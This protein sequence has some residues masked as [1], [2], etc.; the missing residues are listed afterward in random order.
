MENNSTYNNERNKLKLVLNSFSDAILFETKERVIEFVNESFCNLFKIKFS[1]EAVTGTNSEEGVIASSFQFKN[2]S[3]FIYRIE[4]ILEE[5]IPVKSEEVV[6]RDGRILLRDYSSIKFENVLLGHLWIYKE[7]RQVS[8]IPSKIEYSINESLFERIV[9]NIPVDIFVLNAQKQYIFVNKHCLPDE[10]R[11]R[12]IIGKTDTEYRRYFSVRNGWEM[13]GNEALD[14]TI[15]EAVLSHFEI[16]SYDLMGMECYKRTTLYPVVT[17]HG[18]VENVLAFS[19]DISNEKE[20]E[21]R[22]N[23]IIEQY[24][25]ALNC[26]NDVVLIANGDLELNFKNNAFNSQLF[27]TTIDI[28]T[29]YKHIPFQKYDFYKHLFSVLSGDVDDAGGRVS[30]KGKN[31]V[32]SW[33]KYNIHKGILTNENKQGSIVAVLNDITK[34]VGLEENLLEVVKREKELNELK[35]AFVNMVSHEMRTPLAIIS[36]SAEIIQMMLASGKSREEIENYANNILSEVERMTTFMNDILMISKIEAGKIEFN[37]EDISLISFVNEII[38][39][40]YSPWKDNRSLNLWVRGNER[41]FPFDVKMLRHILQNLIENA[42]KYSP[43]KQ[44]PQLRLRYSNT[45]ITFSIIDSGIGIHPDDIQKLF[46]SFSRGRNVGSISGSG[47]GLVVVKYFVDQHK[48][49]IS[50]KSKLNVGTIF[51]VKIPF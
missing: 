19:I 48:G 22:L 12:F 39:K 28:S 24:T 33:Y 18:D 50:I 36:S 44:A 38:Q 8:H 9:D 26:I 31:D 27:D 21:N 46:S 37:P 14:K 16:K 41:I 23:S 35:S 2:P 40:A 20:A 30:L 25:H 42:F 15:S 3:R 49:S 47:I 51:S 5:R 1:P 34:E 6:L 7:Q 11:R 43:N 17:D 32:S 13:I 29:I 10:R 45:Y 4:E